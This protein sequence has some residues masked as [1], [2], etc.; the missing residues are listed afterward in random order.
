MQSLAELE[1]AESSF[2]KFMV[3]RDPFERLHSCYRDKMVDNPH[4]SLANFRKEV[5]DR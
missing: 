1:Y 2:F 3:V 4:W 5:K